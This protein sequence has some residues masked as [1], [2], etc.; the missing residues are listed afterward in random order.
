MTGI[1]KITE[2]IIASARA[3]AASIVEKARVKS[4]GIAGDYNEK[5]K[6]AIQKMNEEAEQT[7]TSLIERARGSAETIRRDAMLA[8]QAQILDET[9]AEAYQSVRDLPDEKYVEFLTLLAGSALNEQVESEKKQQLLYGP[10]EEAEE[11]RV[12][13]ILLNREDHDKFGAALMDAL[14]R[15]LIGKL[16]REILEKTVVADEVVG[17]DGG[18]ILRY[19]DIESNCSLKMIFA[20]VRDSLEG[21]ISRILFAT[22]G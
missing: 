6:A 20:G 15:S 2:K 22:G 4:M 16:P 19:G 14:R 21:E 11:I 9:F 5:A 7:A 13:E 12:Y 8:Q 10:D 1:E 3:E 17:I 18:L